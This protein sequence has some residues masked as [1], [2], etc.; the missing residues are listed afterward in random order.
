MNMG[1]GKGKS[2]KIDIDGLIES[3]DN[4]GKILQVE[5]SLTENIA[6]LK[7][8][9]AALNAAIDRMESIISKFN[10]SVQEMQTKKIGAQVHPQTLKSLNNICTNFVVEVGRQLMAYR[11]KQLE[12]Q[13]EHEKRIACMLEKSKGI[14]LSDKWVKILFIC[15]L[16]Y[17]VLVILYVHFKT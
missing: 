2:D 11:D 15:F 7:Q 13:E 5:R 6:E 12:Q 9:T 1:I 10:S 8:T 3:S 4:E 17:N 14:W 16:L